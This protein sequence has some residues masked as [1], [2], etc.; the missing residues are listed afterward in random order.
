MKWK[1]VA[2]SVLLLWGSQ[3]A[4]AQL[5][6]AAEEHGKPIYET[7]VQEHRARIAREREKAYYAFAA[8][9]NAVALPRS[10]RTITPAHA[11]SASIA[12]PVSTVTAAR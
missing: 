5:R 11:S 4:F 8:R 1:V 6:K 10:L 3:A 9:R 7:L 12:M 2:A